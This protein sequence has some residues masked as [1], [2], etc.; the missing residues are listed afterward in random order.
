MRVITSGVQ[1]FEPVVWYSIQVNHLSTALLAL[2]L[3]PSQITTT[4][5]G[6]TPRLVILSSDAHYLVGPVEDSSDPKILEKLSDES[7]A[8]PA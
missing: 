2:L 8:T 1:N 4:A 5:S 6:P 3:L 7:Y